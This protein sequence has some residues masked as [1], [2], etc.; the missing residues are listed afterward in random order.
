MYKKLFKILI[1]LILISFSFVSC[2]PGYYVAVNNQSK[3]DQQI[4]VS[5]TRDTIKIFENVKEK[6]YNLG[7][8]VKKIPNNPSGNYLEINIPK[9]QIL[10]IDSYIG[11]P[12]TKLNV[13]INKDTIYVD[14]FSCEHRLGG[15][16]GS[17]YVYIIRD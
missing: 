1:Y 10:L 12:S 4:K 9:D 2:D 8:L 14:K 3:F 6:E 7:R 17:K 11:V 5:S 13:I 16:F 15:L